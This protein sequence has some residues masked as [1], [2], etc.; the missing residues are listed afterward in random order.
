[1]KIPCVH[2]NEPLTETELFS[3]CDRC[4]AAGYCLPCRSKAEWWEYLVEL[5]HKTFETK[6]SDLDPTKTRFA[7][8]NRPAIAGNSSV[9]S[10]DQTWIISLTEMYSRTH[11][12]REYE[13]ERKRAWELE[14]QR[15]A[16]TPQ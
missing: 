3:C 16:R 7:T 5:E 4:Q 10:S 15:K 14:R 1:M 12:D 6:V 13:P 2:C 11:D 9:S 8:M